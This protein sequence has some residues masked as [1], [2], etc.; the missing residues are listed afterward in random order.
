M[1]KV[2]EGMSPEQVTALLGKPDRIAHLSGQQAPIAWY[3]GCEGPYALPT[4]GQVYFKV[5]TPQSGAG[6][7]VNRERVVQTY[8]GHG[9]PPSP[10]VISEKELREA[11]LL[12]DQVPNNIGFNPATLVRV[13]NDLLPLGKQKLLAAIEEYERVAMNVSPLVD[14]DGWKRSHPEEIFGI[15]DSDTPSYK[16]KIDNNHLMAVMVVLFEGTAIP[17]V[18]SVQTQSP[19]TASNSAI[20]PLIIVDDVPLVIL[21]GGVAFRAYPSYV[22]SVVPFY[23]KHGRLRQPPLHPSGRIEEVLNHAEASPFVR[24]IPEKHR[25]QLRPVLQRQLMKMLTSLYPDSRGRGYAPPT[26]RKWNEVM[27]DLKKHPIKWNVRSGQYERL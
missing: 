22:S 16:G 17:R 24:Q 15:P 10:K 23:R 11:L 2:K 8:G 7:T 1:G 26:P 12:L 20:E 14:E 6:S 21:L 13:A 5:E 4:L 19:T 25:S 27:A 18:G 3:Y 9:M